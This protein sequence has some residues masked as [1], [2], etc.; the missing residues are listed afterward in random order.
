MLG[1]RSKIVMLIGLLSLISFGPA[2]LGLQAYARPDLGF[3]V[4][5]P[6]GWEVSENTAEG[7]ENFFVLAPAVGSPSSGE[8]AVE[9]LL[10]TDVTTDL[11]ESVADILPEIL[12]SFP[13]LQEVQRGDTVVAGL[14]AKIVEVRGLDNQQ[15]DVSWQMVFVLSGDRGYL[16]ILE[17]LTPTLATHQ[18]VLNQVLGSFTVTP[19]GAQGPLPTPPPGDDAQAP[20]PSGQPQPSGAYGPIAIG[21]QV[22]GTMAARS[23]DEDPTFHTYVVTVPDGTPS[24]TIAV[25]GSG[26]D[27]DL[28]IKIGAPIVDYDD[29]DFID[30]TDTLNPSHTID[31]PAP[32]PIYIDVLNLVP[33]PAAYTLSVVVGDGA[34]SP[35]APA[36]PA[37]QNPLA[38]APADPFVGT[39]SGD[40]LVL[41]L[42]ASEGA[43]SG[44]LLFGGQRS[45]R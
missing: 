39:F 5:Y 12:A 19:V 41:E 1:I 44:R 43:Y 15:N 14:A 40:D 13:G 20:A 25:A 26:A 16:V 10:G 38:P 17:A 22:S 3:T 45:F 36:A 35:L 8:V 33:N 6:S 21:G 30:V 2:Q 28:A 42:V 29:V 7:G 32:G 37:G 27:L 11:E 34:T 9:I 4:G 23:E 24:L 18:P 31:N